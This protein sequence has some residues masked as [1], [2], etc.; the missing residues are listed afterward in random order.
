[1][2]YAFSPDIKFDSR[3]DYLLRYPGDDYVDILGFDDY[4]DFKYDKKRTNEARKRIRIVGA[5][6]NEKKKPC[7][8]T[9]VGYFIKRIIRKK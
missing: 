5:L 4:E 8:L 1:M 3:E 2:L 9:E 7:A 6:A